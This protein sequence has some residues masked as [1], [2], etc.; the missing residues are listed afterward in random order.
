MK[1]TEVEYFQPH[2]DETPFPTGSTRVAA[3]GPGTQLR[4]VG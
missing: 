3:E 1:F 2:L 4:R